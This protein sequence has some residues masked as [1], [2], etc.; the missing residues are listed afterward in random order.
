VALAGLLLAGL[1]GLGL[2]T[3]SAQADSTQEIQ[4]QLVRYAQ[5]QADLDRQVTEI[6][7]RLENTEHRVAQIEAEQVVHRAKIEQM[8]GQVAQVALAR[9]QSQGIDSTMILLTA[10]D[11]HRMLGQLATTQWMTTL[12]TDLLQKYQAEQTDLSEL[13]SSLEASLE[14]IEADNVRLTE[15]SRLANERVRATQ[16]LLS[17]LNPE[18]NAALYP[19]GSRPSDS[20][21]DISDLTPSSG[22]IKPL[23]A[24]ITSPYGMRRHP[25]TGQYKLHDGTDY[26]A[27]CGTPLVAP[28]N[29]V[30]TQEGY[31][32]GYGYRLLIDHGVIGGHRIVSSFNHLSSYAVPEGA[33][34][35]Q[36]QVVAFVG[37]SGQATG[38]HL[39]LMI[40]VDDI[41]VNPVTMV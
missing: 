1:A 8:R 26:G 12:T 24:A 19:A 7:Q 23:D 11:V 25:I 32:G 6:Q 39:H 15:L 29:G 5:E 16:R 34:V 35:D 21:Y 40:W 10:D 14:Q 9:W 2:S 18:Q 3:P 28:A 13:Q 30:V 41:M 17:R 38:C 20:K 31:V 37:A 22:L 36:G 27:P 4:D 33:T